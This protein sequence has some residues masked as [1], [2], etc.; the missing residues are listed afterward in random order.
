MILMYRSRPLMSLLCHKLNLH[1]KVKENNR[2][3]N[4]ISS[5][6]FSGPSREQFG[7][8]VQQFTNEQGKWLLIG[9]PWSGYPTNRT[10]DIY[11]C[12]VDTSKTT[13]KKLNLQALI[14][15]A[16]V[17]EIK[18]DM[19]LGLTLIQNSRTG[20]F[21]T[22][23]PLWAQQCGSQ[24]YATG[25]C[26]E[27]SPSFQ[28]LRSFSPAVQKCSSVIDVVVVC[29]ESKKKKKKKKKKYGT[30]SKAT[31][32][33]VVLYLLLLGFFISQLTYFKSDFESKH[34]PT[35]IEVGLIQYANDPRVVFNLNTYQTKD[36]VVKAMEE[37]YQKGGD[38]T[39]TFKAIDNVPNAIQNPSGTFTVPHAEQHRDM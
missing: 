37:T 26:S 27:L 12:P 7:Y 18:E 1:L 9:S 17:T 32:Y 29:D 11:A 24:Y 28:I 10:G 21:L 33:A 23:G 5:K 38:L 2:P 34:K 16:N 20:G 8:T 30:S 15:I 39:N 3:L 14:N 4:H 6:I 36:E 31:D 22:C 25:V 13:C 19:N 35:E